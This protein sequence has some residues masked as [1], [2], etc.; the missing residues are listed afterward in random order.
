MEEWQ[1]LICRT[2]G[3]EKSVIS[4]EGV[5]DMFDAMEPSLIPSF[6]IITASSCHKLFGKV[7]SRYHPG[8]WLQ[9]L[10]HLQRTSSR[11]E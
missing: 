1:N 6:K 9:P 7:L 3:K 4:R 5:K 2:V 10:W 8:Y 11:S